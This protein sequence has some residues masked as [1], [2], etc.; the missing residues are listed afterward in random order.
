VSFDR[1]DGARE[2]APETR[3]FVG[4]EQRWAAVVTR[5]HAADGHFVYAVRTTG[6]YCRPSSS[7]RLPKRA[8]VEFFDS[9]SD[10]EA[11][12]YRASRRACSDRTESARRRADLVTR[13]R[14]LIESSDRPLTLARLGAWAGMSP[15]HFQRVFKAEVGVSPKAYAVGA[16]ARKLRRRPVDGDGSTTEAIFAACRNRGAATSISFATGRCSLGAL[17]VARTALGIC[18]ILLG[19]DAGALLDGLRA[20]F[21]KAMLMRGDESDANVLREVVAFVEAPA[22]ALNLPLDVRATA[23]QA[24]AWKAFHEIPAGTTATYAEVARRIGRPGAA[25]AVAQASAANPLAILIP[26][27]RV[28]GRDGDLSGC[29]WGAARTRQLL[30][31]EARMGR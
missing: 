14:R 15:F 7:A 23:F 10:A 16:R 13:A 6:I 18:A 26:C 28:V 19:D 29:R 22:L 17:L 30:D 11:A 8:N 2:G 1:R 4:D 31:R 24:R 3:G 20:R 9:A 12:G 25:R 27:H 5:N 21:P